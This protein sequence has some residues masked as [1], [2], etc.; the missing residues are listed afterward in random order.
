MKYYIYLYF[1]TT[2]NK[3]KIKKFVYLNGLISG[4]TILNLK[5]HL[6]WYSAFLEEDVFLVVS[7]K[8]NFE[9]TAMKAIL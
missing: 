8:W 2:I 6:V 1:C 5:I 4:T 3:Y 9:L 7:I